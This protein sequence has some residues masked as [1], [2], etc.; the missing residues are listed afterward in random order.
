VSSKPGEVQDSYTDFR[1][2]M[3][4]EFFSN[5]LTMNGFNVSKTARKL[6]MQQSNLYK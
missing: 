3:E 4:K 1:E 6:G 5:K 2:A